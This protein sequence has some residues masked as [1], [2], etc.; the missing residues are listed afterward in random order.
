MISLLM[1]GKGEKVTQ[2][3]IYCTSLNMFDEF[4]EE[5]SEKFIKISEEKCKFW[6]KISEKGLFIKIY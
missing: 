3:V 1:A 4:R 2:E 5:F 6:N